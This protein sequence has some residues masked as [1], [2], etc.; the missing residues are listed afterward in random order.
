MLSRPL[1]LMRRK[2]EA[3]SRCCPEY[4]IGREGDDYLLR[5]YAGKVYRYRSA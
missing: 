4:C 1:S 2:V 5:N 3:R